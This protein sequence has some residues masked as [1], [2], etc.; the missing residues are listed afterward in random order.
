M[1][2]FAVAPRHG[3]GAGILQVEEELAAFAQYHEVVPQIPLA[4]FVIGTDVAHE[5]SRCRFV[6]CAAQTKR[7]L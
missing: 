6:S 2:I 1:R 5:A 4:D 7:T 3:A